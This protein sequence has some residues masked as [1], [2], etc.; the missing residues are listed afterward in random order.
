MKMRSLIC[1]LVL[2]V[3]AGLVLP[4]AASAQFT[5]AKPGPEH[6]KLKAM[7]GTWDA[8]MKMSTGESK[9]TMTWKMGLGGL[10]LMSSFEAEFGGQKFQ[11]HGLDTYDPGKKKYIGVWTDSMSTLPMVSEGTFDKDGKVLTMTADYPGP[12]GKPVKH[13]MKS[14]MKD[15]DTI[16]FTMSMPGP[17]GK[18]F[19]VM[20]IT[21]KRKK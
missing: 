21:Y 2:G 3:V 18:D 10:W 4:G 13:T 9:G 16:V 6:E 12:D 20:T 11:G 5:P 19:T 17:D 15:K 14:E 1:W 7:E 8:T